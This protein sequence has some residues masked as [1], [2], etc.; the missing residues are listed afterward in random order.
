MRSWER[1][2]RLL[3]S[4]CSNT[5]IWEWEE[6]EDPKMSVSRSWGH[7]EGWGMTDQHFRKLEVHA[8]TLGVQ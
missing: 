8:P 6:A 5:H 3:R 1:T 2:W 4:D 7:K